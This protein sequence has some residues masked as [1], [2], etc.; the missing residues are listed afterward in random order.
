VNHQL[1]GFDLPTLHQE[2]HDYLEVQAGYA[3]PPAD[4]IAELARQHS[5]RFNKELHEAGLKWDPL[6]GTFALLGPV[7]PGVDLSEHPL[8]YEAVNGAWTAAFDAVSA[9]ADETAQLLNK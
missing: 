4:L 2:W 7:P 9:T 1:P 6:D 3:K 8:P 5:E